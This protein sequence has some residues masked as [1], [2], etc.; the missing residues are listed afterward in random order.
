SAPPSHGRTVERDRVRGRHGPHGRGAHPVPQ[1]PAQA[2]L[3]VDAP[4][5]ARHRS[6]PARGA[7]VLQP[8]VPQR[9]AEP[10]PDGR[11]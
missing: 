11:A 4:A 8:F 9:P 7:L 3:Y 2:P 10:R 6:H 1:C 5:R